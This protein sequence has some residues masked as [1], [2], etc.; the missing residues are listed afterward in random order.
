MF[1]AYV[2]L[3][4]STRIA[5]SRQVLEVEGSNDW[6]LQYQLDILTDT[7]GLYGLEQVQQQT[8]KPIQSYSTFKPE[9]TYWLRLQLNSAEASTLLFRFG[10]W[11]AIEVHSPDS[12]TANQEQP[13]INGALLPLEK[14]CF[15]YYL[16]IIP[17]ELPQGKSTLFVKLQGKLS[18]Y[19]PQTIT[20]KVETPEHFY[21]ENGVRLTT[22][23][24]FFGII[25]VM[26]LYNAIIFFAVKDISYIYYI[27]SIIGIGLY[28]SNFYGFA[29]GYFWP[30]APLWDVHSFAFIVPLTGLARI[31][32]TRHYLHTRKYFNLGEKFLKILFLACLVPMIIA[33]TGLLLG[34]DWIPLAIT[35]VAIVNFCV[36]ASM[37]V[38]SFLTYKKG[39]KPAIF[40]FI[41]NLLFV[42]GAI[43]FIFREVELFP[44]NFFTR[45]IVQFGVVAQV[46]LFSLGLANRLNQIQQELTQQRFARE[47]LKRDR[48]VER[49]RL[50]EKQ[51]EELEEE[52]ANRTHD[53]QIKTKELEVSVGKLQE[54]EQ[55]LLE[56]NELKNKLFSVIA[57][58][59]RSPLSTLDSFLNILTKHSH[60]LSK[61]KLDALSIQT[62]Q[63]LSNLSLLLDNLLQWAFAHMNTYQIQFE[64]VDLGEAISKSI[65]L[66]A[67][68]AEQKSIDIVN[69]DPCPAVKAD[70]DM[71][72]FVLRNLL[73]NAIKFSHKS[74]KVRVGV[75]QDIRHCTISVQD[76][77]IGIPAE[78]LDKVLDK[79]TFFS[80]RGTQQEGG[81]GIGLSLCQGFISQHGGK[82]WVESQEG[83]G[84]TFYFTLP[85]AFW[86]GIKRLQKVELDVF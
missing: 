76:E 77:G 40:F 51:K 69:N 52:V 75:K 57:H 56:L 14:R 80:S 2:A 61:E 68:E 11:G 6:T 23:G 55:R 15:Q 72:D 47:R 16:P 5:F 31:Q 63:S 81:I 83:Q 7:L 82:L 46:V 49:K 9:H 42:L 67:L 25:I 73:N 58:D 44:D 71:L 17:L 45:Y 50:I 13:K 86:G 24:L 1:F 53:L 26:A 35:T 20:L 62:K 39:Y 38:A 37:L 32:F 36:L 28:F 41:A 60:K 34:E 64:E 4:S 18:Q 59:L 54:S 85:L 70:K 84:A 79:E 3:L 78:D 74:G 30:S 33:G 22:Q 19:T 43:L 65:S 10:R 66:I 27:L 12:N 48:E 29:L 8:F 21:T